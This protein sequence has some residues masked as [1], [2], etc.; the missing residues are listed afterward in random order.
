MKN[1]ITE[2][3]K[4]ENITEYIK[5]LNTKFIVYQSLPLFQNNKQ[6]KQNKSV[7]I[8]PSFMNRR[9]NI[10]TF[11]IDLFQDI[12]KMAILSRS[13][14]DI[15]NVSQHCISK[16]FPNKN[17]DVK[18]LKEAADMLYL[19]ITETTNIYSVPSLNLLK[20]DKVNEFCKILINIHSINKS[21]QQNLSTTA[22]VKPEL[23][24]PISD[25]EKTHHV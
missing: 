17:Y 9:P 23:P 4:S 8:F 19:P 7:S 6:T 13:N 10:M 14:I 1:K 11:D 18:L 20:D 21:T 3:L 16:L 24:I 5:D 15:Q 22:T 2:I 25:A 12:L